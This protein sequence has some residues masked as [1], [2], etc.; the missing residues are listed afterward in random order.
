MTRYLDL[1][2]NGYGGVDFNA[3]G[4]GITDI[5][6]A[7]R[8]LAAANIDQVLATII[9]APVE[10]MVHRI[11]NLVAALQASPIVQSTILGLHIEGPFIS[12]KPGYVGAHPVG[13][14]IPGDLRICQRLCAAGAGWIRLWTLAPEVDEDQRVTKFLQAEQIV[15]A[16]GHSN[17]SLQ[18]LELAIEAGV[19]L[20]TH[21][22]NGCPIELPRH[23][24]II[25]RVF[26]NSD[27][28]HISF[29]ADGFHVPGF[30][31][32]QY[33]ERL[34]SD[35]IIIVSDAMSAAGLGPGRYPLGEQE[36]HVDEHGIAWSADRRQLAGSTGTLPRMSSWLH[37][38]L[39]CS[40]EDI[41]RWTSTNPRRLL[42]EDS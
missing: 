2:V 32:K 29:I 23:D 22:G 30:V 36:I 34:P 15:V 41:V 28:L 38:T 35:R 37:D 7:C 3:D 31:L 1:Q 19:Q 42:G 40:I 27:K 17:A 10:A 18:E 26:A 16:A 4:L 20:F 21:L 5:E 13:A 33:L 11:G 39:N 6:R 24:N 9:T 14:V 8:R 12:P 25:N